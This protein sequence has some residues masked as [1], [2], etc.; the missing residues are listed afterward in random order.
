MAGMVRADTDFDRMEQLAEA[1][2]GIA[3]KKTIQ[4]WR[5]MIADSRTVPDRVKLERANSFV[6]R[7]VLYADDIVLWHQT[8]Y[9][10]TP[11]ETFG[12]QAGDCEDY[13]IAKYITLRLMDIPVQ[14]LRLFYVRARLSGAEGNRTQAH[15]VL[16][17][18]KSPAADPLVLD[19][20]HQEILPARSRP[21][22]F[23]IF[24]FNHEGLWMEGEKT[25]SSNPRTR[26]SRWRDVLQRMRREGWD[27]SL[28]MLSYRSLLSWE[29]AEIRPALRLADRSRSSKSRLAKAKLPKKKIAKVKFRSS[30]RKATRAR[31]THKAYKTAA[32]SPP[33]LRKVVRR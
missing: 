20:L 1:Q 21:D 32:K 17:Y 24:S 22:L 14:K 12:K 25:S 33:L 7:H 13:A 16:S 27:P 18:F 19:I 2:Y 9:W 26:L 31:A 15:M 23:P 28:S 10:A 29:A 3:A 6:N 8:D 5:E 4:D 30:E 11:L